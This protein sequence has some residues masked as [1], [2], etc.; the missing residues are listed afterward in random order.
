L[1]A[2]QLGPLAWPPWPPEGSVGSQ[3]WI[4]TNSKPLKFT[5]FSW[6]AWPAALTNWLPL[7][8]IDSALPLLEPPDELEELEELDELLEPLDELEELEELLLLELLLEELLELDELAAPLLDDEELEDEELEDDELDDEELDEEELDDEELGLEPLELPE[9]ELL[10][11]PGP[12]DSGLLVTILP[13]LDPPLQAEAR[14]PR[15]KIA[16]ALKA[17]LGMIS[18]PWLRKRRSLSLCQIARQAFT[19]WQG[20]GR[21]CPGNY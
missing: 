15:L 20:S 6:I 14:I 21:K 13:E 4:A 10:L 9:L 19:I 17:G 11:V 12:P 5:P 1:I 2:D 16:S 8:L 18:R 7:I 3:P